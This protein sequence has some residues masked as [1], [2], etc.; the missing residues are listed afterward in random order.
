MSKDGSFLV[1][2]SAANDFSLYD[3]CSISTQELV[4]AAELAEHRWPSCRL[5]KN[6]V[7][8]NLTIW[9]DDEMVGQIDLLTGRVDDFWGEE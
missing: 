9:H 3:R 7:T 5:H 6:E 8:K 1:G 4:E 2:A